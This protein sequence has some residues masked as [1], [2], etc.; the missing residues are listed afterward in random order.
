MMSGPYYL[1]EAAETLNSLLLI[2]RYLYEPCPACLECSSPVLAQIHTSLLSLLSHGTLFHLLRSLCRSLCVHFV[3]GGATD[4]EHMETHTKP[5]ERLPL[6]DLDRSDSESDLLFDMLPIPMRGHP[7][8]VSLICA[9]F[10]LTLIRSFSFAYLFGSGKLYTH[11]LKEHWNTIRTN[12]SQCY[13]GPSRPSF[14]RKSSPI[15]FH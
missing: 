1:M 8:E 12:K 14:S 10:D 9:F 13:Y 4:S 7:V 2:L 15:V 11:T 6:H 3:Q 5:E